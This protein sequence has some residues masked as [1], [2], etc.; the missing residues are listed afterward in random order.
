MSQ[1]LGLG[2]GKALCCLAGTTSASLV[3]GQP[4]TPS[5]PASCRPSCCVANWLLWLVTVRPATAGG[6]MTVA[7]SDT[8]LLC[9]MLRPLPNLANKAATAGKRRSRTGRKDAGRDAHHPGG[10]PAP[11][12]RHRLPWSSPDVTPPLHPGPPRRRH[13]RLLR[14]TQA[15][16]CHHQYPGQRA[17][18]GGLGRGALGCV[19]SG[20]GGS[21]EQRM[22]T[23]T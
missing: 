3:S 21:L 7:F 1:G 16:V 8:N 22:R 5:A 9:D 14:A 6:G 13:L 18:Q 17:L 12:K 2:L 20:C 15:A 11:A 4:A 10:R 23:S 19:S